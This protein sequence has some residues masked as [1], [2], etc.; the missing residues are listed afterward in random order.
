MVT[1]PRKKKIRVYDTL[2]TILMTCRTLGYILLNVILHS[3]DT[4]YNTVETAAQS[5]NSANSCFI[6]FR[7]AVRSLTYAMM[8]EM[9]RSSAMR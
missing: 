9:A 2:P 6:F 4:D 3:Q 5:Q 1:T 8:L 7:N